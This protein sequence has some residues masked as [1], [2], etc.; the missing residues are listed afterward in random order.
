MPGMNVRGDQYLNF[1]PEEAAAWLGG[2][3]VRQQA[4]DERD[5]DGAFAPV[6]AARSEKM[7]HQRTRS[8]YSRTLRP[9]QRGAY[10]RPELPEK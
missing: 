7:N 5:N 2:V 10:A 3:E 8:F 1:T 6:I 4:P 9:N